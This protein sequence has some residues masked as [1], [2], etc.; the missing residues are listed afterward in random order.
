MSWL[1]RGAGDGR[2]RSPWAVSET[3]ERE[4]S[5]RAATKRALRAGCE[6]RCGCH[7]GEGEGRAGGVRPVEAGDGEMMRSRTLCRRVAAGRWA[8]RLRQG[9]HSS[10]SAGLLLSCSPPAFS[11]PAVSVSF[12]LSSI[13]SGSCGASFPWAF[14]PFFYPTSTSPGAHSAQVFTGAGRPASRPNFSTQALPVPP[15]SP[16]RH[17][18]SRTLP[19]P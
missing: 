14:F 18:A 12:P 15:P 13:F 7:A 3:T 16:S 6:A 1:R 5:R 17:H 19:R 2:H 4:G 11:S 9:H 10:T 8:G